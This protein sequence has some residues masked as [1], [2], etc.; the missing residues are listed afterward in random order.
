MK[1]VWKKC[2]VI[3]TMILFVGTSISSE[4]DNMTME[5]YTISST[6][7]GGNILYVGGS[8][9]NNYTKIQ[10]AINDANDGDTIF[11]YSNSSPYYE[12]II[13]N[14]SI[15]LVGED[16]NTTIIDGNGGGIVI[17]IM[18]DQVRIM[19]FTVANGSYGFWIS[20]SNNTIMENN[21][22]DNIDG[23]W[24]QTSDNDKIEKNIIHNSKYDGIVLYSC[25]N[26]NVIEGNIIQKSGYDGIILHSSS[27]NNIVRGN[28]A[29]NNGYY[30]IVLDSAH[31][32]T[33][34]ENT[35]RNNGYYGIILNS[36]DN[37][38]IRH[39][40]FMTNRKHAFFMKWSIMPSHNSWDEN[41]WDDW[42]MP[43]PRLIP[44]RMKRIPWINFDWHPAQEPY[45]YVR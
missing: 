34:T 11:V 37:N 22:Q 36:S 10:D 45:P 21:I 7:L 3:G 19:K 18:K 44:G 24:L 2:L 27:S 5:K 38:V 23:I 40:N 14:K 30:G 6:N 35:V 26:N 39:N 15:S 13:I 9:P 20:S 28:I 1:E 33:I 8:G 17:K 12:H 29:Q 31:D 42:S 32:N 25:S 41:Y 43:V 16:K 4:V